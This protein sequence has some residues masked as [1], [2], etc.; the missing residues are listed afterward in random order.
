MFRLLAV[1]VETGDLTHDQANEPN[2]DISTVAAMQPLVGSC[3][4]ELLWSNDTT[5][6]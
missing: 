1:S 6:G 3:P 2:G 5:V 4:D